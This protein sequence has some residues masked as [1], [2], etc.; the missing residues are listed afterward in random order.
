MSISRQS[1]GSRWSGL[2]LERSVGQPVLRAANRA[3][4]EAVKGTVNT[5]TLSTGAVHSGS[6]YGSEHC[7]E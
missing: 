5:G 3:V 1:A 7:S 4:K 6:A 2:T